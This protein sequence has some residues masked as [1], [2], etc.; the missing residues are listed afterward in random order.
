[1]FGLL[2]PVGSGDIDYCD[3]LAR[4][5]RQSGSGFVE[6]LVVDSEFEEGMAGGIG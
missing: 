2:A 3:G 6:S 4:V 1:M 5:G